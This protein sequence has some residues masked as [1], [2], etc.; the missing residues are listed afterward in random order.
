MLKSSVVAFGALVLL[1]SQDVFGARRFSVGDCVRPKGKDYWEEG[2]HV[3]RALGQ[4][5]YLTDSYGKR[6]FSGYG[7][8]GAIRFEDEKRFE[9]FSC[10]EREGGKGS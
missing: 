5:S 7:V 6:G 2:F 9:K 1:A 10:P 8:T 3:V 4:Y